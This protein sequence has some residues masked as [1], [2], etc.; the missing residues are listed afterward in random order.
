MARAGGNNVVA[1]GC[2]TYTGYPLGCRM[3]DRLYDC[4]AYRCATLACCYVHMHRAHAVQPHAFCLLAQS[5]D[6][7]RYRRQ[8]NGMPMPS[9]QLHVGWKMLVVVGSLTFEHRERRI[10]ARCLLLV[11][12]CHEGSGPR[13]QK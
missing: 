13:A 10:M 5:I 2:I 9:A 1:D 11:A 7:T 3:T 4:R 12:C 6:V 8:I